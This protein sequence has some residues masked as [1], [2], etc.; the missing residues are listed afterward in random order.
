MVKYLN[1]IQ[2]GFFI[3]DDSDKASPVLNLV[4]AF[5]YN[6]KK[7]LQ[8]SIAFGEGLVGTCA[9]EK[10]IINITE[11]PAGY[12][13]ITS[14][15]GDTLPDNLLLIPVMHENELIGVLEIASLKKYQDY[16]VNFSQEVARNLGSTIV[17]TRNN[18]RTSELL[19]MSQQQALEM[20]EQ[21]EEMRQNMEELKATQEESN[22]REDELRG[23]AGA[24]R[25]TFLIIEYDLKG[26]IID[27]NEKLCGFLR[28]HRD[29]MIGKTHADIFNGQLTTDPVF[30]E[31]LENN[32]QQ[33]VTEN[34]LV[35]KKTY[36]LI[37]HF[38][39][40]FQQDNIAVKFINFATDDRAG[41]S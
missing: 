14:G 33:L 17:Y 30:W 13:E 12:I 11:I 18:Q 10:Q 38:T 39:T 34:I 7:Y 8:K 21:E 24:I 4:S 9:R 2:G 32:G 29:D 36:R 15:L 35:G 1:A 3:F 6:R 41:N 5:A 20:A 31:G 40:V 25:N 27:V 16:E 28:M 19:N 23:F 22:R 26:T 37:E